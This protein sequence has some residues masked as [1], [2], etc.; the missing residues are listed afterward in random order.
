M[1]V[2]S[3]I[4][5]AR[6]DPA[7]CSAPGLF[8]SLK[9]GERKK[10]KLDIT[11]RHGDTKL[12]FWG[13]EPLGADDLRVLQVLV[14]FAGPGG[15]VLEARPAT[16]AGR[17]LR[18]ELNAAGA[19]EGGEDAITVRTT[20]YRLAVEVGKSDSGTALGALRRCLDRLAALTVIADA[21]VQSVSMRLCARAIDS[22][23]GE[24]IVALHPRIASAVLGQ[25]HTRINIAEVRGLRSDSAVLM[26]QRLCAW[27]DPGAQRHVRVETLAAYAWPEPAAS[28]SAERMRR[29]GVRKALAELGAIGWGVERAGEGFAIRRPAAR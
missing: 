16:E 13:P 20:L 27:V 23:T 26:H 19:G 4:T 25:R 7:L 15:R 17:M 3:T 9:R 12:R 18:G 8:R 6:H 5:H 28:A 1:A 21:G 14:A 2:T 22:E 10:Q 11:Y 29:M 24:L